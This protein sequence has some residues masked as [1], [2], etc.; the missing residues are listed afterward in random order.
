MAADNDCV[1]KSISSEESLSE[2]DSAESVNPL[3]NL[4][5][6]QS[7]HSSLGRGL[8]AATGGQAGNEDSLASRFATNTQ[9]DD[10]ASAVRLSDANKTGFPSSGSLP[11]MTTLQISRPSQSSVASEE[12]QAATVKLEAPPAVP[13]RLV[14]APSSAKPATNVPQVDCPEK[15][16]SRN[17]KCAIES[18]IPVLI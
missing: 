16:V 17:E 4:A 2:S 10:T 1:E 11:S 8:T 5:T 18:N 14:R 6:S 13:V 12:Q 9:P 15:I 3:Y 7:D